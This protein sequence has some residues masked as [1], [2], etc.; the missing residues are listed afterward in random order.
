MSVIHTDAMN[1]VPTPAP[2][3]PQ[4]A[5]HLFGVRCK[6]GHIT[7]FDRRKVCSQRTEIMRGLD[8]LILNCATCGVEMAVDVDCEG[9]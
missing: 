3:R 7:T 2:V 8:E 5:R 4:D 1:T 9:Y 6:N